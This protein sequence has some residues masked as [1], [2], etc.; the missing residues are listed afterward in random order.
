MANLGLKKRKWEIFCR[1]FS[2]F[3]KTSIGSCRKS[4]N[5]HLGRLLI[6]SGYTLDMK[7]KSLIALSA[8]I[9][10]TKCRNLAI[11]F[12][13]SLTLEKHFIFAFLSFHFVFWKNYAN[14]KKGWIHEIS[15]PSLNN[16]HVD[17]FCL[18][19]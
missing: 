4:D 1:L 7:Q 19:W 15:Y 17:D 9:L 3:L 6:K 13:F 16:L 18:K 2:M 14:E 12:F 11:F 8:Y 5:N 10:K